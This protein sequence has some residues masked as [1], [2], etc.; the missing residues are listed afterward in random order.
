MDSKLRKSAVLAS[1]AVILLVSVLVLYVND[2]DRHLK[3]QQTQAPPQ[4]TQ[5]AV[6]GGQ[7]GNDLSAFL[8]DNT[9]FDQDTDPV[10]EEI[11]DYFNRLSMEIVSEERDLRIR[12]VNMDGELVTGE[13]F[14]VELDGLG[15]YKDLNRDGV[16]YISDLPAGDYYVKLLPVGEYRVPE[17]AIKVS[18]RDR[19]ENP[20]NGE[21]ID[22]ER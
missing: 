15:R 1:I 3:P 19:V 17:D 5:N 8:S 22:T 10:L 20:E 12:I 4:T 18:V 7:I 11:K 9:F 13:G 14:Y 16:I 6:A 21:D 2:R